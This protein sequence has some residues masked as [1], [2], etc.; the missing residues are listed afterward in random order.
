[1]AVDEKQKQLFFKITSIFCIL[2]G[3]FESYQWQHLLMVLET[4]EVSIVVS[5]LH[6]EGGLEVEDDVVSAG[7]EYLSKLV[8]L[9]TIQANPIAAVFKHGKDVISMFINTSTG[10][11][12]T[13]DGIVAIDEE[14]NELGDEPPRKLLQHGGARIPVPPAWY[15]CSIFEFWRTSPRPARRVSSE[16]V[17]MDLANRTRTL[18]R[19][20]ILL[21]WNHWMTLMKFMMENA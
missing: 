6:Y 8:P 10:L 12:R 17:G 16:R 13:S 14:D 5:N 18:A 15:R 9:H 7:R 19:L 11:E 1:M 2:T 3:N 21:H 4:Y 20:G